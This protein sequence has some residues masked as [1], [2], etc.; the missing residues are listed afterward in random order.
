[1]TVGERGGSTATFEQAQRL[2]EHWKGDWSSLVRHTICEALLSKGEYHADDLSHLNIPADHKNVVGSATA[3]LVNKGWMK[4][5]GRRRTAAAASKGRKA[6]VYGITDRGRWEL[7]DDAAIPENREYQISENGCWVWLRNKNHSGY[8]LMRDEGSMRSAHRVFYERAKGPVPEG[9]QLDHLCRNRACVN[10]EHL[11]AV[12]PAE[13]MHRSSRASVGWEKARAIRAAEGQGKEIAATFGVSEMTVS[14]IRRN[15]SWRIE[16]DPRTGTGGSEVGEASVA[17]S[18]GPGRSEGDT[19]FPDGNELGGES[20]AGAT[21]MAPVDPPRLF[22]VVPESPGLVDLD[23]R[24]A[25]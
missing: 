6:G 8:G 22:D 11:E 1:M 23:Q 7:G 17:A 14:N 24:K 18:C 16:D 12:T 2:I 5:V 4:E 25:A 21:P 3:W 9:L 15:K 20:S 10:P 19:A 13:N